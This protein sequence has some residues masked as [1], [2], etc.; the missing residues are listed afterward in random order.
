MALGFWAIG[1]DIDNDHVGLQW[2]LQMLHHKGLLGTCEADIGWEAPTGPPARALTRATSASPKP[3]SRPSQIYGPSR[4]HAWPDG[5]PPTRGPIHWHHWATAPPASARPPALHRPTVVVPQA[6]L[7]P[8]APAHA[9]PPGRSPAH[10]IPWPKPQA[11]ILEHR[12]K[13][14]WLPSSH[15]RLVPGAACMEVI[16]APIICH[17]PAAAPPGGKNAT[18]ASPA[19]LRVAATLLPIGSLV[20][21]IVGPWGWHV[22]G[23]LQGA[24]PGRWRVHVQGSTG[25]SSRAGALPVAWV[26]SR[27]GATL[28]SCG[29]VPAASRWVTPTGVPAGCQ[30]P[31]R[32]LTA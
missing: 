12:L 8:H 32:R 1:L 13:K 25:A 16:A 2:F 30:L 10:A 23:V 29:G 18:A 14:V 15:G 7:A 3:A 5:V 20:L 26:P 9:H 31:C 4:P 27:D 19:A 21:P 6:S 11:L 24:Q 28:A 17:A 22:S